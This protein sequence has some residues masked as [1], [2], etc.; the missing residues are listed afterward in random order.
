MHYKSTFQISLIFIDIGVVTCKKN[1]KKD[2][3]KKGP[4]CDDIIVNIDKFI[5]CLKLIRIY[6]VTLKYREK[7]KLS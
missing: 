6:F 3:K 7:K 1:V 4:S 2:N 5:V